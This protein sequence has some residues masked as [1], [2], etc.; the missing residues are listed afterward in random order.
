MPWKEISKLEQRKELIRRCLEN[1]ESIAELAR[2]FGV[3]RQSAY[4]W[5]KR[6]AEEGEM[7]L[8]ERSRAPHRQARELSPETSERIVEVRRAHPRWGP[9]KIVAYLQNEDGERVAAPST[10]GALLKREGLIIGRRKRLRV[11][12][13]SQPLQHAEAAN[14]VWCADF[15]GW[16]VCGDGTRCDPLTAT[17]AHSRFLLR[18]QHV[19]KTDGKHVRSVFEAMFRE[20]GMPEAIRTDNGAPFASRAPAGLSRLSMWWLQL[21]IR[22]ERIAP[23]RP[24][25]NGRHERMH[26]TLK[27]ET[28]MPPRANLRRQQEAF[29]AFEKEYNYQRPHEALDNCTPSQLYTPSCRP[30]PSRLPELCYPAGAH[31]RWVSQQGSVKWKSRRAFVS[32]VLARQAV[33]L[34]EVDDELFEV[35]YGP[36]MLGWLDGHTATFGAERPLSKR[37]IIS[38][39]K[40][41]KLKA[42]QQDGVAHP[43]EP[44]VDLSV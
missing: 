34:V 9:R 4:K 8:Q 13:Y 29:R 6:Q 15:K 24:D 27:Q 43:P 31:L 22:H 39:R 12:G 42:H 28:A 21:G 40:K 10:V 36:L 16:F 30:Y 19:P 26:Q 35:Y 38:A 25:Q 11:P 2:Q 33:G 23:G 3:S 32:E 1:Q 20:Y 41:A 17:D 44:P 37:A 5:L 7:G 18:C 14:Q